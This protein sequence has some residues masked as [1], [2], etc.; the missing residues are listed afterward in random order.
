M[1]F[2]NTTLD[3]ACVIEPECHEDQRGFFART[4]CMREF[5]QHGLVAGMVQASVS[6]N[7]KKGTL[8][9]LHY[10]VPPSQE[11]KLVRCTAGAIYDVIL[12]LRPKSSMFLQ[13]FGVTLTAANHQ[14]LYIPPGFAHGFQTLAE[15]TEVTYLMTDFYKPEYARG[16]R[17]NDP[18]FGIVWPED[19]RIIIDRD[20]SYQDFGPEVIR[21]MEGI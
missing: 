7:R 18:A 6:F 11:A 8:R 2:R 14:G 15:D 17:W 3:G 10:Q 13:Y 12:D 21:E 1:I 4:W 16:V 20:A 5:E 19:E 9:G